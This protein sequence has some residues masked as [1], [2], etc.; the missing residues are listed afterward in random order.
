MNP[1]LT[2]RRSARE[3]AGLIDDPADVEVTSRYAELVTT[4]TALRAHPKPSPR[5]EFVTD[6]RERLMVAAD[7]ALQPVA[8]QPEPRTSPARHHRPASRRGRHLGVAVA[9]LLVVG[10][11]AGVAAAAQ[12]ALPG[13][14][15]YPVK[16]S[17]ERVELQLSGNDATRGKEM[18]AQAST[19]LTEVREL[20]AQPGGS[21]SASLVSQTLAAFTS[22]ADEGS[23]LLFRNYQASGNNADI[24]AVREFTSGHMPTLRSLAHDTPHSAVAA[25]SRAGAA[26]ADIDRQARTLCGAC[27]DQ[28]PVT[29]PQSLTD[30][31]SARALAAL[32]TLPTAQ[33]TKSSLTDTV[34]RA[35]ALAAET[36]AKQANSSGIS[37]NNTS[38]TPSTTGSSAPDPDQPGTKASGPLGPGP[39]PGKHVLS[40]IVKGLTGSVPATTPLTKGLDGLDNTLQGVT[41]PLKGT[42]GGAGGLLG[43][44]LNPPHK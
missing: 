37:T 42:L 27:S 9:A 10:G 23:H 6:L 44:L 25:F 14:S 35:E 11:S 31:V 12:S 18:L 24:T 38:G 8:V 39:T 26:V 7:V 2:T 21:A 20:A 29:L 4:V 3:F 5:P 28:A 16:R 34:T 13:Q 36:A 33:A 43:S 15:L 40:D 17:I 1:Q 32:V 19:R 41:Q 30:A 22:S